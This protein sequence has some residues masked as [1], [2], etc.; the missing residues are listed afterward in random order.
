MKVIKCRLVPKSFCINLFG[1]VWARDVSWID[2]YIINHERIHSAQQ[3]ELLWIPFYLLYVLEFVARLAVERKWMKA[4]R[5][6]SFEQEAYWHGNDLDYLPRR[7]HYAMW[8]K[9]G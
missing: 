5:K 3:R 4:Y 7:R 2:K 1:T 8:R 9:D 6:I